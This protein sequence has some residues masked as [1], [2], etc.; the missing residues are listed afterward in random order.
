MILNDDELY[1]MQERILM[2]ERVLAEAR[3]TYSPSN[4]QAMAQGYLAEIVR[5][6]AEVRE[7]LSCSQEQAEAA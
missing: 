3:K 7:Y 4:Y 2:F 6:Q 1:A 5:M